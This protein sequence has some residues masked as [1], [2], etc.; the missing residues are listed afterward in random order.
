MEAAALD[1]A[2]RATQ[3][4]I[5]D[6]VVHFRQ[7]SEEH[8]ITFPSGKTKV[9]WDFS[10]PEHLVLV[11]R[12]ACPGTERHTVAQTVFRDTWKAMAP[13]PPPATCQPQSTSWPDPSHLS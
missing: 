6:V 8:F 13:L 10:H 5:D 2:Q 4:W 3:G 1:A 11:V 9:F 12:V 7:I